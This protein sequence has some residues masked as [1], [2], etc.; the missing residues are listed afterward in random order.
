MA[1]HQ[2][3]SK[4]VH[5]GWLVPFLAIVLVGG[6]AAVA[7]LSSGD[8]APPP[9]GAAAAECPGALTVVTASSFAPVLTAVAPA[10]AKGPNCARLDVVTADGRAAAAE[11]AGRKA[12]VWIPDDAAWAGTQGVVQLAPASTVG[13][14]TVLATSPFYL[15]TDAGTAGR[16]TADG[17][18]WLALAR[19]L[20]R[21]VGTPPVTLAV[22]DPAGS[23]DGMLAAGAV[24][25]AVW[26]ADG[27]DASAENMLQVMSVTRT[28]GGAEPALPRSPGEVG[29]VPEHALLPVLR[30]G[31][32]AA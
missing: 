27:M 3:V 30:G 7:K 16:V 20:G 4:R 5:I 21:P 23:G 8:A 9:T 11:V 17:A 31:G 19:L 29:V 22:R 32:A 25:E 14:G 24:G 28:V 26:I 12:D 13:S 6:G 1:R 2:A 15:V 18:G 10:V